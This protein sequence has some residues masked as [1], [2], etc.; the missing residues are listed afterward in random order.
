MQNGEQ[1]EEY[2]QLPRFHPGEDRD[3][4][5]RRTRNQFLKSAR[6]TKAVDEPESERYQPPMGKPSM[7]TTPTL[8]Y[9]LHKDTLLQM[10]TSDPKIAEKI[11]VAHTADCLSPREDNHS[12][13]S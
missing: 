7:S 9:Q 2:Q 4:Q 6:E 5:I 11:T 8:V 13:R 10:K 12:D 1:N 3:Q